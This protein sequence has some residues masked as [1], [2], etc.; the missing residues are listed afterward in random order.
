VSYARNP[1]T[2]SLKQWNTATV[3][4]TRV[5]YVE[6]DPALRGIMTSMLNSASELDV[7]MSTGSPNEALTYVPAAPADVALLDL[8]LG[9]GEMN[10]IDLGTG[11]AVL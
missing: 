10:G 2:E 7:V 9:V 6:N 11:D 4:A 5:I 8:A 1:S 3:R